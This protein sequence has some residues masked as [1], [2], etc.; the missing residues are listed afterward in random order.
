MRK[1]IVVADRDE[2]IRQAFMTVFSKE[3]YEIFYASN[4]KEVERIAGRINAD[5]YIVNV[6]LPKT[7]G[8][9]VYK[10]LQ[11]EGY[12]DAAGFFFLKDEGDKTDLSEHQADGIVEKPIN[13]FKLYEAV[14]GDDE[15]IELTDLIEEKPPGEARDSRR[16]A[17][18]EAPREPAAPRVPVEPPAARATA[19]APAARPLAEQPV[20]A[21]QHEGTAAGKDGKQADAGEAPT[22]RQAIGKQLRD[23]MD[24]VGVPSKEAPIAPNDAGS[25]SRPELERQFTETLDQA[26]AEAAKKM[27][28][29]LAPVLAR[30]VEEY[31]RQILL[32]TTEKVV[33]E[34]IDKLLKEPGE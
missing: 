3:Q 24:N 29:R 32:E 16:R 14:T 33:R 27:S 19:E 25:P 2:K 1:T 31:V 30:Y 15:V 28:A 9:D 10:K 7:G 17:R 4:G 22:L 13:F 23:A 6:N 34:E 12:L 5:F 21:R 20:A 18:E 26:V 8:I 11:Q